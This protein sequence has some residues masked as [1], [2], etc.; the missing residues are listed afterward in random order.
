MG[1]SVDTQQEVTV[2]HVVRS[3]SDVPLL[4]FATFADANKACKGKY[5]GCV[6]IR[7]TVVD[8]KIVRS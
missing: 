4:T 8:G 3:R 2:F 7:G 6:V 5:S 1:Y